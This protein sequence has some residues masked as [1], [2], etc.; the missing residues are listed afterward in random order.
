[1]V[2]CLCLGSQLTAEKAKG[3]P[4]LGQ[5]PRRTTDGSITAAWHAEVRRREQGR[6]ARDVVGIG[7]VSASYRACG[8]Y[9]ASTLLHETYY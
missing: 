9:I 8:V 1:M 7:E 3:I 2:F 6:R 5:P 4:A